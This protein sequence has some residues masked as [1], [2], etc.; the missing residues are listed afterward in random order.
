MTRRYGRRYESGGG[1]GGGG[2]G[3]GG[4]GYGGG[5]YR[6][7][8]RGEERQVEL[9][10]LGLVL[11]VFVLQLLFPTA[12]SPSLVLL[13][14]GI[15]LLG[16]AFFQSQRRWRVNPLTWI[17]G[18]AMLG[19]GIIELQTKQEPLGG[20]LPILLFGVVIAGSFISG[21]F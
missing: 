6:R 8:R 7:E 16:G 14:G 13:L 2:Y 18:V 15:I 11:I 4:G 10:T 12:I 5:R 9:V 17:G 1:Y 21:E 19:A 3:R 20:L